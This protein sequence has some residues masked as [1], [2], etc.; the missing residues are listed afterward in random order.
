MP[1]FLT[2]LH[3]FNQCHEPGGSA[4]GGRFCSDSDAFVPI[5][6]T[7]TRVPRNYKDAADILALGWLREKTKHDIRDYA[8]NKYWADRMRRE[9]LVDVE[10]SAK[11]WAKHLQKQDP[12]NVRPEVYAAVEQAMADN[13]ANAKYMRVVQRYGSDGIVAVPGSDDPEAHFDS[14]AAA[15]RVGAVTVVMD[16]VWFDAKS[17]AKRE[18]PEPGATTAETHGGM[19]GVLRHEYGHYVWD[20]ARQEDRD[21]FRRLILPFRSEID[22]RG[23]FST[24]N[25]LRERLTYYASERETEAFPEAF[26]IWTNPKFDRTKFPADIQPL[27]DWFDR[28]YAGRVIEKAV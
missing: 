14:G 17:A 28:R 3:E 5:P 10:K 23:A 22:S 15:R 20:N 11:S 8:D 26:S 2:P 25:G 1:S 27:F 12:A 16:T 4:V 21:E 13:V 9:N 7:Q 19:A 18:V 24:Y 6:K